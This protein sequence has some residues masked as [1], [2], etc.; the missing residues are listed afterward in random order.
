MALWQS[1]SCAWGL[2]PISAPAPRKGHCQLGMTLGPAGKFPISHHRVT[3][4]PPAAVASLRLS[5][6]QLDLC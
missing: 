5:L 1:C 3:E 2:D 4:P 6:V